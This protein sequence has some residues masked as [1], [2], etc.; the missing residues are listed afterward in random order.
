M[1]K[2]NSGSSLLLKD[3][4]STLQKNRY[5]ISLL[6]NGLKDL[7]KINFRQFMML[8]LKKSPYGLTKQA[9]FYI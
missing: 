6:K 8:D 3:L 9:S 1:K 2:T 7:K 4:L 5:M